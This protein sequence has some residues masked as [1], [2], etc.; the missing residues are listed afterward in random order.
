MKENRFL[1]EKAPVARLVVKKHPEFRPQTKKISS[2]VQI[3]F[4]C[5][6][7]LFH[8]RSVFR[9]AMPPLSF[10]CRTFAADQPP[11]NH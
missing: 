5:R 4:V 2:A 6:R 1:R 9:L 10:I 7:N 8:L 3:N 11:K